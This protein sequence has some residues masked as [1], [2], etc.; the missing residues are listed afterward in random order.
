M[1]LKYV[2]QLKNFNPQKTLVKYGI[3]ENDGKYEI[4]SNIYEESTTEILQDKS[5]RHMYFYDSKKMRKKMWIHMIDLTKGGPLP[6]YTDI[7][8]MWCR[9]SFITCPIGAPIK[10]IS[11]NSREMRIIKQKCKNLNIDIDK[12]FDFFETDGIFCSFPCVKSYIRENIS[13]PRF[14][15]AYNN[16]T[17]LHY[18]LF[19]SLQKIPFAPSYKILKKWGGHLTIEQYRSSFG[20]FIYEDTYNIVSPIMFPVSNLFEEIAV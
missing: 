16:L 10:Y 18:K 9:E 8:C 20:K 15:N 17:L 7:P 3:W 2:I 1:S 11:K 13:H 5:D 6:V 4:L 19:N 12:N 14:K